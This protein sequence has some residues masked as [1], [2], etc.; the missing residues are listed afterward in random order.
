MPL[1]PTP[2]RLARILICRADSS[3][4][5]YS[6]RAPWLASSAET[7]SS[8]VDL[9]MPGSPPMSTSEP[10]TMP[11]PSTRSNSSMPLR[12]RSS[13]VSSICVSVLA[14]AVG[15]E[16]VLL[17]SGP[18]GGAAGV[19]SCSSILFQAPQDGQRPIHFADS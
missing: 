18:V 15:A 1:E 10:G 13:A 16:T 19:G 9:P 7:C 12:A 11:P 5:T 14:G 4:E 6:T 2:R 17:R 3:P 8:S